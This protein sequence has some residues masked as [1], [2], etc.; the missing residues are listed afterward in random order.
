MGEDLRRLLYD[1][2]YDRGSYVSETL[3]ESFGEKDGFAEV[4]IAD[5][6]TDPV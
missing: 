4:W 5:D 1:T 6:K 2:I 3:A